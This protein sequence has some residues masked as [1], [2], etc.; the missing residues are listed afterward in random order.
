MFLENEVWEL[1]PVKANFSLVNLQVG[2]HAQAN[3]HKFSI[4]DLILKGR[5][6]AKAMHFP[7]RFSY[8][9]LCISMEAYSYCCRV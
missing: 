4:R 8:I 1:C 2:I 5:P 6:K 9:L 7:E 3:A